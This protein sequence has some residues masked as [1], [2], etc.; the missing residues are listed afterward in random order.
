M[1]EQITLNVSN[2][3]TQGEETHTQMKFNSLTELAKLLKLAGVSD[4]PDS[5]VTT[6]EPS[7]ACEVDISSD[8]SISMPTDECADYD[9]GNNITSRKGFV[10]NVDPYTYQGDASDITHP[11]SARSGDNPL[12]RVG[13]SKSFDQYLKEVENSK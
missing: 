13:E 3:T 5:S 2:T 10:Y 11:V 9:Y 4:M 7:G 8:G 12:R 1:A 6:P